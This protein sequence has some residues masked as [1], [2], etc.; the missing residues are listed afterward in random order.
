MTVA[1]IQRVVNFNGIALSTVPNLVV[2]AIDDDPDRT[3]N[4]SPLARRNASVVNS[5]FYQDRTIYI[6]LYINAASRALVDQAL[7]QLMAIIQGVEG[8]LVLEYSGSVRAY[9]CTYVDKKKNNSG[10]G[11]ANVAPP[12]GGLTDFTLEFQCSDAFGYDTNYTVIQPSTAYTSGNLTWQYTQGGS[13]A[14]QVPFFQAQYTA[15]STNTTDTVTIGN[16]NT[17]QQIAVT[18]AW[19]VGDL[20][21]IDTKNKTVRV[22]GVDVPFVGSFPEFQPSIVGGV[23]TFY[24]LDTFN[25]RT[26]NFFS[27]VYN[28][29]V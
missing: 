21:T 14:T 13:A 26:F 5:A 18:R 27:Y 7:D 22:N 17:G 1:N 9:T 8:Q 11:K 19:S 28:R 29:Y 10:V 15:L 4:L 3:V 23:Q 2:Y 12:S 20:L 16:Q 6:S 24:Y 25:S